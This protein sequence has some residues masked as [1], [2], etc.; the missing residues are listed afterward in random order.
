MPL[1]EATGLAKRFATVQAVRDVSLALEPGE[2][3]GLLGANGAGKSTTM[4]MLTGFFA[5]D[6]GSVRIGGI[7]QS[8]DPLGCRRLVGWMPEEPPLYPDMRVRDHLDHVARLRGIDRGLR[9]RSVVEAIDDAHLGEVAERPIRQL[10]KGNRQRVGLATALIG[11]PPLLILDEPTSGLDPTQV[12]NFRGLLGRLSERHGLLLST[13]ILAEV[14][15]VCHRV[16][17][18]HRG[19]RIA[20]EPIAALQARS[21]RAGRVRVRLRSGGSL[22]ATC[23]E[24]GWA[25]RDEGG[26]TVVDAPV[27][28]RARLVAMAEMHGGLAEL[29]DE[30]A[31]LEQVFADLVADPVRA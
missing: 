24:V 16:V 9:R 17:V 25:A 22:A 13:H 2:V 26:W 4:R 14:A 3:V 21:A 10:S 29:C 20:D 1:L 27:D 19:R 28:D 15:A 31:S 6:A 5:P 30:R 23:A 12:S 8:A 18:I 11:R 7:D